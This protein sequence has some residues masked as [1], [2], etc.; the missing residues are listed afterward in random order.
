MS[1]LTALAP[2]KWLAVRRDGTR[3]TLDSTGLLAIDLSQYAYVFALPP[4]PPPASAAGH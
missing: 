2:G 4:D 1:T 3:E